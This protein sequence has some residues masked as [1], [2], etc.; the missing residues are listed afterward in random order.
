MLRV[1]GK[2]VRESRRSCVRDDAAVCAL[3][4]CG[5]P[6]PLFLGC[7]LAPGQK[8]CRL[9]RNRKSVPLRCSFSPLF[10]FFANVQSPQRALKPRPLPCFLLR[11]KAAHIPPQSQVSQFTFRIYQANEQAHSLFTSSVETTSFHTAVHGKHARLLVRL[12]ERSTWY[13][14]PTTRCDTRNSPRFND[15]C[16]L[17][18]HPPIFL[19]SRSTPDTGA[20]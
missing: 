12:L 19:R 10:I 8:A 16:N 11:A 13:E 2:G 14:V 1:Q 4:W 6:R 7:L 5:A 3:Q 17:I 15:L 18:V 20:S 9:A